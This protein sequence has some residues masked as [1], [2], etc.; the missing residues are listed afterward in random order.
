MDPTELIDRNEE[1][2]V[3]WYGSGERTLVGR[4][5]YVLLAALHFEELDTV[6]FH[7]KRI[8]L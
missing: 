5:N 2:L 3:L 8:V 4:H 7:G 6:A 1:Q